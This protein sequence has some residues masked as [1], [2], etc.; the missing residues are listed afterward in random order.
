[1]TDKQRLALV[2]SAKKHLKL[3]KKGWLEK[4]VGGGT[5]WLEAMKAL[6]ALEKDLTPIVL[7]NLGPVWVGGMSVLRQDLTHKTDG[8]P[9]Y[10]AFDDAYVQGRVV[11]APEP[12]TIIG[13]ATGANPGEAFYARGQSK[14]RYWFGHLD[15][16]QPIGVKI[17]KGQAVGRVAVNNVGGGPHVHVGINVELIAGFGKHLLHHTNY[18]HGAPTVGEQLKKILA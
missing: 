8:I 7:P 13:P 12:L 17:A 16:S 3:T 4:P 18:T 15:R 11:I 10:P 5:E 14:L 9:L 1:V 2:R 6:D